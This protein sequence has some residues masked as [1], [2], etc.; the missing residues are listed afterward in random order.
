MG[1]SQR[2]EICVPRVSF[3]IPWPAAINPDFSQHI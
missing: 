2:V 3:F 1:K